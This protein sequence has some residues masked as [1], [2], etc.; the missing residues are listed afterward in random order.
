MDLAKTIKAF[1]FKDIPPLIR[2]NGKLEP[3]P[4][5]VGT[6]PYYLTLDDLGG[7][8]VLV[9]PASGTASRT[10]SND[11]VADV[12]LIAFMGAFTSPDCLINIRDEA[13]KDVFM[14]R[15]IHSTTI[16][17]QRIFP[18][19]LPCRI[20]VYKKQQLKIDV[21]DLSGAINNVRFAFYGHRYYW[22]IKNDFYSKFPEDDDKVRMNSRPYFYTTQD[23]ITLPAVLGATANGFMTIIEDAD[24]FVNGINAF[25]SAPFAVKI[26]NASS[27]NVQWSN[28]F[29]MDD[30]FNGTIAPATGA[31]NFLKFPQ[32]LCL[33]R[34]ANIKIEFRNLTAAANRIFL[35]L[36]GTHIYYERD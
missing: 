21:T 33:Q 30:A 35:T 34:R 9:V 22:D 4:L 32:P 17:G 20:P 7:D 18:Y 8:N 25:S 13:R 6:I 29:I 31:N 19:M 28:S 12:E 11:V 15:P 16:I 27:G 1:E 26:T 2:R 3:N 14:N 10:M 23:D 24:F 36:A 5:L